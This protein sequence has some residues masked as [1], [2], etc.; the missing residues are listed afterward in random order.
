MSSLGVLESVIERTT[1]AHKYKKV[2]KDVD[3]GEKCTICLCYF[4]DE[5]NVRRLPCMH[6][7]HTTCVD[8]WLSSNKR[9]PMCHV[10]IETVL[11]VGFHRSISPF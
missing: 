3:G 10:D 7:Y 9:C 1:L 4:K 6:L 5:E 11:T 8:R 2:L